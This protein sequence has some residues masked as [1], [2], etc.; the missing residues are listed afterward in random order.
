MKNLLFFIL[1]GNMIHSI[2]KYILMIGLVASTFAGKLFAQ[3]HADFWWMGFSHYNS[4]IQFHGDTQ[5]IL[6]SS[7]FFDNSYDNNINRNLRSIIDISSGY[8]DSTGK[9]QLYTDGVYVYDSTMRIINRENELCYITEGKNYVDESV[10]P[11]Y[12]DES[13]LPYYID[14]SLAIKTKYRQQYVLLSKLIPP[15]NGRARLLYHIVDME[16]GEIVKKNIELPTGIMR[17]GVGSMCAYTHPSG[18]YTWLVNSSHL[19]MQ[20][21]K[22]Y[23]DT[24]QLHTTYI[25]EETVPLQYQHAS[26]IFGGRNWIPDIK[27]SNFGNFIGISYLDSVYIRNTELYRQMRTYKT[28]VLQFDKY[29]GTIL[30]DTTTA[31][32]V[33]VNF[34]F[35]P[36]E[37]Y[38]YQKKHHYDSINYST[39]IQT[40]NPFLNKNNEMQ[41]EEIYSVSSFVEMQHTPDGRIMLGPAGLADINF[42]NRLGK[43][44]NLRL[45]IVDFNNLQEQAAPGAYLSFPNFVEDY[46]SH[47]FVN[48]DTVCLGDSTRFRFF[49]NFTDSILFEQNGDICTIVGEDVWKV[50]FSKPGKQIFNLVCFYPG[51][52]DTLAINVYIDSIPRPNLGV[53]SLLCRPA[54]MLFTLDTTN[55]VSI[56]WWDQ[57]TSH[58]KRATESGVYAVKTT[59]LFCSASDTVKLSFID[60]GLSINSL[61]YGDS[62]QFVLAEKSLDSAN[63]DF[64]DGGYVVIKNDQVKHDYKQAGEYYVSATMHK[65]NLYTNRTDTIQITRVEEDFLVD[66]LYECEAIELRPDLSSQTYAFVWNTGDSTA[67]IPAEASGLYWLKI[68]QNGCVATDSTAVIIA[69]CE[70][71]IFIPNSFTPNGDNLNETFKIHS[72]CK[73]SDISITMY[74]RWGEQ[75]AVGVEEWRGTYGDT[76]CSSGVYIW[77]LSYTDKKN[78]RHHQKGTVHLLR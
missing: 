17:R 44:C 70:C 12:I 46:V 37:K 43:K 71:P 20:V 50:L 5:T 29:T 24:I 22:V 69:D 4:G 8:C 41:S 73:I 57:T 76:P 54:E 15:P 7:H 39:L 35:S 45:N 2:V 18:E 21:Y 32:I 77:T 36:N 27:F 6:S 26:G 74:T 78:V 66:S 33:D 52:K 10:F 42:P 61:C 67:Y 58:K 59:T 25:L 75:V 65:D 40:V 3:Y 53:D 64:G 23:A 31:D 48:A 28:R 47:S 72:T 13:V 1:F 55:L 14:G 16:K 11:Y 30:G 49:N 63:L 62:T 38:I 34:E 19:D 9:V 60:C 68:E 56:R 51:F